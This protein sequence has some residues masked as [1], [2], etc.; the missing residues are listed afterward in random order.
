MHAETPRLASKTTILFK[1]EVFKMVIMVTR[2]WIVNSG[3]P[4]VVDGHKIE[5]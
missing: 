3:F 5:Y 4:I 2:S 1:H